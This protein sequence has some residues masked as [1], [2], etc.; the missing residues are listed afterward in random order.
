MASDTQAAPAPKKKTGFV[1]Q[2]LSGHSAVGLAVGALMYILC[3]SG[4]LMV[5]HEEFERWEQPQVPE[6]ATVTPEAAGRAADA[7]LARASDVPHHFYIGV[8][9]DGMPRLGISL[10]GEEGWYADADGTLGTP[11]HHPWAEFLEG[12]HYYLHLPTVLGLTVV[13]ILGAMLVG[14][15]ISGLLA[16]PRIFRDAFAMRIR[17]NQQLAQADIHNRLSVWGAPF[18]LLVALTGAGIGLASV[19]SYFVANS[20]LDGDIEAFYEPVFGS[21]PAEDITPAPVFNITAALD[22]FRAEHGD[23]QPWYVIMHE[24]G[25]VGQSGYILARH[26]A[27]L[28]YGE[29]YYFGPDGTI[30]GKLGH[31][32][33]PA[34][35][36]VVASAYTVHFGSFGGLPV[37]LIYGVL[38]LAISIVSATGVNIWLIKRR[39][40]G[41]A[42]PR[43]ERAWAATIWGTPLALAVCFTLPTVTAVEGT[44]LNAIFWLVLLGLVSLSAVVTDR[45]AFARFLRSAAGLMIIFGVLVKWAA[46]FGAVNSPAAIGV[47]VVLL[48]TAA[49]LLWQG[50]PVRR[51]QKPVP[52]AAE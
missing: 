7:G 49:V 41:R 12:L 25:T 40:K 18:H 33:G 34:G 4:T 1:A 2:M 31:S 14:L 30:T 43:L 48:A 35:Q 11:I 45:A 50:W 46:H 9:T 44:L 19:L 36:Q 15:V 27:R 5:F 38:G 3:L 21:D 17:G 28:I 26:P 42:M 23:L 10:D 20:Y 22:N 6:F 51:V 29:N 47:N 24:P 39:E 32:D 13:G 37:K 16:H 8:P 52:S